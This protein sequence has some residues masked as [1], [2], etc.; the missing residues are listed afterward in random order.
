MQRLL[1]EPEAGS[2]M[3]KKRARERSLDE[4]YSD[5]K[6][7]NEDESE[8]EMAT[9]S[10]SQKKKAIRTLPAKSSRATDSK[11]SSSSTSNEILEMLK[12]YFQWQQRMELEWRE[13]LEIHY[14]KRQLFE[15]EWRESMEKLERERLMAEQAWREREEERRKRQDIRAEGMDALLKTLL[16]KLERGNNL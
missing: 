9:Q 10:H 6:E 1:L 7:H 15:Q 12:G 14:N 5:L 4:G 3:T 2:M 11:S 13:I 8:E 16:N